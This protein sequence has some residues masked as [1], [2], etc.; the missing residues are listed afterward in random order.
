MSEIDFDEA[1]TTLSRLATMQY[2][3]LV[4]SARARRLRPWVRP[5]AC[6]RSPRA[7]AMRFG[8]DAAASGRPSIF[9]SAP[10]VTQSGAVP[11]PALPTPPIIPE[12]VALTT[13]YWI[14]LRPVRTQSLLAEHYEPGANFAEIYF[15]ESDAANDLEVLSFWFLWLNNTGADVTVDATAS[16]IVR[17][18]GDAFAGT[19]VSAID[20]ALFPHIGDTYL[21]VN[22]A[23]IP[24]DY[25][26]NPQ[27][28]NIDPHDH[29]R[30]VLYVEA[31]SDDSWLPWNWGN[32]NHSHG[33]I[34]ADFI[35]DY[36]GF[37]VPRNE[38]AAFE[39]LVQITL[40]SPNG[41]AVFDAHSEG[42]RITCPSINL[43]LRGRSAKQ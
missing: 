1:R 23:V 27:L 18:S 37:T 15:E 32:V 17:A 43:S 31:D 24:V 34:N 30:S 5:L 2:G 20:D 29:A 7:A 8:R 11:D 25:R 22:A 3:Q 39:V 12:N 9:Q 14:W 36:Q 35:L 4:A 6:I 13:A 42:N 41:W 19:H 28:E 40:N 26:G 33:D 10:T 16:L 21:D 38:I